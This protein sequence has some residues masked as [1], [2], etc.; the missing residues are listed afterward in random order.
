[1]PDCH[2]QVR[3]PIPGEA[4]PADTCG[5]YPRFVS[6]PR[7]RVAVLGINYAPEVTGVAPYT[8][9]LATGLAARGHDV[10]VLTGLPHYPQW[11]LAEGYGGFR[12]IGTIDGVRVARF[13]HHVPSGR[14][15]RRRAI[16][17]LT[18]GLQL[19]TA[20]WYRPDVVVCVSPP[21]L[22][23]ALAATRTQ[24]TPHRPALGVVVHDVYSRALVEMGAES[25]LSA[26]AV[27]AVEAFTIRRADG[28]AVIHEGFATDLVCT[29]GVD[30]RRIRE[31]RNWT[32]IAVPDPA[33][34]ADFRS[35]HKWGDDEIVVL[36]AGN[37]GTKQG[38]E[39]VIDSARLAGERGLRVRFVLLGDGH[40]R[41]DLQ[42]AGAGVPNLQFLPP[43]PEAEF[44]AALGAADVLLVNELPGVAHMA[45]P[46]KLTSY[47]AAGKPILAATD[48][49][50]FTA[51]EIAESDA[52][53]RVPAGRPDL[54]LR[55]AVRL[56]TDRALAGR[57]SEAGRRYSDL[58]LSTTGAIDQYEQW[59]L[60]LAATRRTTHSTREG[61]DP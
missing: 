22:A 28:V 21:L 5:G 29:F 3:Y 47:F 59:I 15:M 10:R 16:M 8:T 23:V 39:N 53:I 32:H 18:F 30:P 45:V 26:R 56:G 35:T 48:E 33:A 9:G 43:V 40:R 1:M 20:P 13:R 11:K 57:L 51:E 58:L 37:M 34:S 61:E 27:R 46:S 49:S 42:A 17:E 50:G 36:H 54:L 4:P 44:P 24:L 38:L 31:V 52:G 41:T 60:D 2:G 12:W 19:L 14:S 6:R 7:I 55:E 25:G